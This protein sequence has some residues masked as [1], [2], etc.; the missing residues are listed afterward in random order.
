MKHD[1]TDNGAQEEDESV[2]EASQSG[3]LT[4]GT[5]AAQQ[6]GCTA[7][8]ARDLQRAEHRH[9]R[10]PAAASF[11]A[12]STEDQAHQALRAFSENQSWE[13]VVKSMSSGVSVIST[14]LPQQVTKCKL[15]S[16]SVK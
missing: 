2:D 1:T 14:I 13:E 8:K 15:I 9:V 10:Q 11:L 3:I 12:R 4:V 7:T 16:P 5:A 6:T